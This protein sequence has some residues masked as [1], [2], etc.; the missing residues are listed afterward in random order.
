MFDV[1]TT[2]AVVEE[3][4]RTILDGRIQRLGMVDAL[5]VAMEVYA[6]GKRWHVIASA[7]S[8][9]PRVHLVDSMPST[10]PNTITPFSLQL[11]KYVRGGFIVDITQPPLERIITLSIA[12]RM[13]PPMAPGFNPVASGFTPGVEGLSPG[14]RIVGTHHISGEIHGTRQENRRPRCAA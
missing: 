6:Q 2:G 12:K 3:F 9:N 10:D 7:N 1:L 14:F 4:R 5:T 8:E 11:R 13:A